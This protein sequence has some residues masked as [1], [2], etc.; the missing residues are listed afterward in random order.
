MVFLA[1]N[2]NKTQ[3]NHQAT[4]VFVLDIFGHRLIHWLKLLSCILLRSFFLI[5]ENLF[6]SALMKSQMVINCY[7]YLPKLKI[8]FCMYLWI[9]MQSGIY[10]ILKRNRLESTWGTAVKPDFCSVNFPCCIHTKYYKTSAII[11]HTLFKSLFT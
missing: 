7:I 3:I 10:E 4:R 6:L 5:Q 2:T 1:G 8:K 9:G 11:K